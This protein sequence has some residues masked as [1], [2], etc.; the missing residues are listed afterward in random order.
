MVVKTGFIGVGAMGSPMARNLLA[1]GIP[2]VVYDIDEA[3]CR[4]LEKQGAQVASSPAAVARDAT[5]I[6]CMVD[7]TA[8][9]RAVMKGPSGVMETAPAGHYIACM[10][11]IA[12]REIQDL[13][14]E[15]ARS[16]VIFFDAPVSGGIER[17][18][19]GTLA[20]FTGGDASAQAVFRDAF[21]CMCDHVFKPGKVGQGMALKLVNNMLVQI[22]SVAVAEAMSLGTRA[23]LDPQMIYDAVKVST[24][25]SVAF[26]M[27]A[28][29]MVARNFVP[30]GPLEISCKDQ[31]LETAFAKQLGVP[32]LL[33]AVTQQVY[34]IARNM[35]LSKEDA[36]ALIKVYEHLGGSA[37]A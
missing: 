19:A 35:G 26:E 30:G 8:Q 17:A 36:A 32:L 14:D 3:K 18:I 31:E 25:Y 12:P 13:H 28:P 27:R 4:R 15:L 23:G 16:G 34:Q 7:T 33:A 6:L 2:L 21:D 22:N 9:V 24:G 1:A 11:T 10:S 20:M 5:R 29:R 37:P